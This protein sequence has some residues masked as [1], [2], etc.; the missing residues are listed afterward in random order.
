MKKLFA[1][2]A[3]LAL[4]LTTAFTLSSCGSNGVINFSNGDNN[5]VDT[6][7]AVSTTDG[8]GTA[9]SIKDLKD[10]EYHEA[11][12]ELTTT[13]VAESTSNTVTSVVNDI[14][15]SCVTVVAKTNYSIST[16]SGVLFAEDENLGLSYIVTCFHVISGSSDFSV[17]D[18]DGNVYDASLVGGYIDEDLAVLSIKKTGLDYITLFDNS[19]NLLR[20]M[21]VICIG[22]PLG[23]LPNSVSRG[24]ISYVNRTIAQNSYTDRTLI[25]TDVAINSGNSG[26]GLFSTSGA[27]IGIVSNKYSSSSIDNLGFA[28]PINTVKST[29][30]SILATARYD[31]ANDVWKT[32]YVVGDYEYAFT[33]SIVAVSGSIFSGRLNYVVYINDLESGETY[34]G[35]DVLKQNDV[36]NS[37]TVKYADTAK[38]QSTY[39]ITSISSNTITDIMLFLKSADLKI[40]DKLEFN[41]TRNNKTTTVEFEIKQ[42]IYTI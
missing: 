29:I 40:G 24:I 10:P 37:I 42:F 25:Q 20:G 4:V 28:I 23:T 2:I 18:D 30:E 6:P 31:S 5:T 39:A 26:G 19:D 36:V 12:Y 34:S 41:I 8:A 3:T 22:N 33:L 7:V 32:G 13:S 15:D 17:T 21:D 14:V 35:S 38:A 16:G 9:N 27:L 1:G 11:T